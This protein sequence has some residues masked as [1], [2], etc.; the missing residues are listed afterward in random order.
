MK[1]NWLRRHQELVTKYDV[2][3]IW[4]DGYGFPYGDYGKEV[5]RTLFENSLKKNGKIMAVAAGKISADAAIV[6]DIE[7]GTAN[8]ILPN[9]WQGI[10]TSG[11]GWFYKKDREIVHNAR[12]V[13]EMM[14]D[15][16]SK[17]GNLLLNVELFPDGTIPPEEKVMLDEVGAWLKINGEA[18][19]ASKPWKIFGDNLNS[20]LKQ[21]DKIENA[22][23]EALKKQA[24]PEQ[25]N[26]R[27]VKSLPYGHDEVR[28]TTKGNI[29]YVF[30]LNP[31]EGDILLPSLGT[32]SLYSANKIKQINMLGSK[33]K[34]KY[35]QN[36]DAMIL[37]IP[38]NRPTQ[39]NTVFE[40]KG[41][42]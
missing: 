35:K 32:K 3:M 33:E 25:F 4:F 30:V 26:Q 42:L 16:I 28:F 12:T 22:D 8:E 40:I 17:N 6:K 9:P 39:Y 23:L 31:A 38:S 13:I 5:C 21:A 34:I 10:I 15:I 24:K 27:T 1:K 36:D 7:C 11:G 18:V 2:D 29:L 19:Y 20:V 14:T 37:T 41:V